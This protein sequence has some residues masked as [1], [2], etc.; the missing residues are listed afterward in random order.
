[1]GPRVNLFG[2]YLG[3]RVS[4]VSLWVSAGRRRVKEGETDTHPERECGPAERATAL[5]FTH[6][7]SSFRANP[8]LTVG[9][10]PEPQP[11]TSGSNLEGS[12]VK[13]GWGVGGG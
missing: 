13:E 7:P 8:P 12:G 10:S 5:V 2:V 1:M 3:R 6:P 11:D 4:P 9:T